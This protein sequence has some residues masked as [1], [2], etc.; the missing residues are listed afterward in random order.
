MFATVVI[1]VYIFLF[2]LLWAPSSF[3]TALAHWQ[4]WKTA[5][6]DDAIIKSSLS[7]KLK[8]LL[9]ISPLLS[10]APGLG[11]SR[12]LALE[13]KKQQVLISRSSC[14]EGC[15]T[16]TDLVVWRDY[17]KLFYQD[18]PIKMQC[19]V[20][21]GILLIPSVKAGWDWGAWR[22]SNLAQWLMI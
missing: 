18:R 13:M 12:G 21:S 8:P 20:P 10:G 14:P 4:S 9:C 11:S 17:P 1:K 22:L 15:R 2:F 6:W 16:P 19:L 5:Q 7:L 3:L